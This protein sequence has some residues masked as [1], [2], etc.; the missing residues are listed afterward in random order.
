MDDGM[1]PMASSLT[2]RENGDCGAFFFLRKD[3]SA[4]S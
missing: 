2:L 3:V 4:I 1:A